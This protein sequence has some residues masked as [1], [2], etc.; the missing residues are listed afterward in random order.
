[1]LA[2]G[3]KASLG[4]QTDRDGTLGARHQLPQ[5]GVVRPPVGAIG[6]S[7]GRFGHLCKHRAPVRAEH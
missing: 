3:R 1:M 4:I 7:A 2:G 6:S 5:Q